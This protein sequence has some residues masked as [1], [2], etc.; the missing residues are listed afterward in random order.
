[1]GGKWEKWWWGGSDLCLSPLPPAGPPV[2]V[3][4]AIEVA[5]IDHIS[6]ANMV[7]YPFPV[8]SHLWMLSL[9]RCSRDKRFAICIILNYPTW[10]FESTLNQHVLSCGIIWCSHVF[11]MLRTMRGGVAGGRFTCVYGEPGSCWILQSKPLYSANMCVCVKSVCPAAHS[12]S[13]TPLTS[14]IKV[15]TSLIPFERTRK[16]NARC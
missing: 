9:Y 10:G 12:V 8:P 11:S 16:S 14:I 6:E 4:M 5:S 15:L 13:G 7:K 1:M 3:A 2:N